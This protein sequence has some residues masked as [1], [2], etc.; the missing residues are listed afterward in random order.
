MA[1][2]KNI[3]QATDVKNQSQ[4]DILGNF[5]A[6][7]DLINVNHAIFGSVNEGK[8]TVVSMPVQSPAPTFSSGDNGLYSFLNATTNKNEL[9]VHKQTASGTS[10]IPFTASI[11][12]NTAIGSITAGGWS[13]LPTGLLIKWGTTAAGSATVSV[14]VPSTAGGPNFAKVFKVFLTPSDLGSGVNFNCGQRTL[15]NDT[16]GSFLFQS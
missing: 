3:P 13:Y 6:I 8:H 4:S 2:N 14:D 9:Y 5:Q 10:E 11:L 16:T 12:S 7:Y 1:Y 15:A